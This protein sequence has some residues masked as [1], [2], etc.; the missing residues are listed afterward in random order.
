MLT[1]PP[2]G[3]VLG[4]RY[5][6]LKMG[7]AAEP[8]L[9]LRARDER[10][11]REIELGLVARSAAGAEAM[12][13]TLSQLQHP[14]LPHVLDGGRLDDWSFVAFEPPHG[15]TSG[16]LASAG[17]LSTLR[18]L[19]IVLDV[20]GA[21]TAALRAGVSVRTLDPERVRLA[22]DGSVRLAELAWA[23]AGADSEDT[24]VSVVGRLLA[25]LVEQSLGNRPLPPHLRKLID[26]TA[27]PAMDGGFAKLQDTVAALETA[28]QQERLDATQTLVLTPR[29]TAPAATVSAAAVAA[30]PRSVRRAR[31]FARPASPASWRLPALGLAVAVLAL[32]VVL[33]PPY[34][35]PAPYCAR[36]AR[37]A[38]EES[39]SKLHD[40]LGDAMGQPSE[41]TH[42]NADNHDTLQS[43]SAGLA[44]VRASS[45]LP[46]FTNGVEHWALSPQG[47]L[48]WSGGA[49]DPPRGAAVVPG[50]PGAIRPD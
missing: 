17:R 1:A 46:T 27:L 36:G 43:T 12:V 32:A 39:L 9:Y 11:E 6:V 37:P 22:D 47:L 14:A 50:R 15:S 42:A 48:Y 31:P 18:V 13:R 41:C 10:L 21:L 16:E 25:A 2:L 19:E 26:R 24:L 8:W 30:R 44:Y 38:F 3:T 23:P 29:Q 28:I 45:G 20:A 40:R 7:L 35:S 5:A 4:S 34:L 33:L 49:V